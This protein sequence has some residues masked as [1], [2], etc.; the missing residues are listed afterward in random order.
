MWLAAGAAAL[1]VRTVPADGVEG[2][3]EL[4][5]VAR[6]L[7]A[8]VASPARQEGEAELARVD[9]WV[10]PRVL[11]RTMV[12]RMDR[13]EEGVDTILRLEEHASASDA[14]AEDASSARNRSHANNTHSSQTD[15]E[16]RVAKI[17]QGMARLVALAEHGEVGK[18]SFV[19]TSQEE[20]EATT[21]KTYQLQCDG[22]YLT[23]RGRQVSLGSSQP[24]TVEQDGGGLRLS[25]DGQYL[26]LELQQ[27]KVGLAPKGSPGVQQRWVPTVAS[28]EFHLRSS[29]TQKTVQCAGGSLVLMQSAGAGYRFG[30]P[31]GTFFTAQPGSRRILE[32]PHAQTG[33]V[34]RVE[35]A[36]DETLRFAHGDRYLSL[37][38]TGL[39]AIPLG[40]A[41]AQQGW[42][43]WAPSERGVHLEASGHGLSC[44]DGR[45][46][47][48]EASEWQLEKVS[49]EA[50]K[51]T[52]DFEPAEDE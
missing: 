40:T 11:R 35:E 42:A 9:R 44:A 17:E 4:A 18:G 50:E 5:G 28:S 46:A 2:E 39:A 15:L 33:Q 49:S 12:E 30:C 24:W 52:A 41:G 19:Q 3:R 20:K 51:D 38:E 27:G 7:G 23:A 48:G 1:A 10:E 14:K 16:A 47:A 25:R 45:L 31:G 22:M 8:P 21:T 34:W 32:A 36:G 6:W 37:V 29:R 43:P 13:L 26:S